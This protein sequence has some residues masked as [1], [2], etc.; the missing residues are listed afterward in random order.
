MNI[1]VVLLVHACIVDVLNHVIN[2]LILLPLWNKISYCGFLSVRQSLLGCVP[3]NSWSSAMM[4]SLPN[5]QP[6]Q[7]NKLEYFQSSL[8]NFLQ[9]PIH[10]SISE[11]LQRCMTKFLSIHSNK[12][13]LYIY[14]CRELLYSPRTSLGH[15]GMIW[16]TWFYWFYY[17]KLVDSNS[18]ACTA[19]CKAVYTWKTYLLGF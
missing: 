14:T 8:L 10:S 6:S 13:L 3:A 11:Q 18:L 4:G 9:Q 1:I 5:R 17:H 12:V 15:P 7:I 19:L 2:Q 16:S